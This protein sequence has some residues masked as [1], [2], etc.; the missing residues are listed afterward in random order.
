MKCS[1]VPVTFIPHTQ[2]MFEM[3]QLFRDIPTDE[4]GYF[5]RREPQPIA[6]IIVNHAH[7]FPFNGKFNEKFNEKL[8]G[9]ITK[10][11]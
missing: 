4:N 5:I 10:N 7:V 2:A 8:N 1:I 6:T 9:C 3:H 11:E